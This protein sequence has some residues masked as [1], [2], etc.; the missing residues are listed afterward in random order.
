MSPKKLLRLK[1]ACSDID[2]FGKGIRFIKVYD[3][4]FPDQ[5]VAKDKVRKVVLCSG[6]VYYDLINAR[7]AEG[8]KDV[9]ILRVEELHPFPY[10]LLKVFLP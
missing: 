6:Q 4:K 7:K 10:A 2:E 8:K 1:E 3:E 9:A 5:I